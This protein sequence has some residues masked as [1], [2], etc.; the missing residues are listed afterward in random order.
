VAV[1]VDRC[2]RLSRG[3]D[4]DAGAAVAMIFPETPGDVD[5]PILDR[6]RAL[7][8]FRCKTDIAQDAGK[9]SIMDIMRDL[10]TAAL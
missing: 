10:G 9:Y 4:G 2:R 7:V 6:D 1:S 8:R 5:A 3:T